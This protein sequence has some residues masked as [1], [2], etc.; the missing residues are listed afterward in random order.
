MINTLVNF[1][2]FVTFGCNSLFVL[3]IGAA[4]PQWN[5]RQKQY[6]QRGEDGR[7]DGYPLQATDHVQRYDKYAPPHDD[8]PEI[9][10]MPRQAPQA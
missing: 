8:L 6:D 5:P 2:L 3:L 9:V 4:F 7:G 10:G 1:P